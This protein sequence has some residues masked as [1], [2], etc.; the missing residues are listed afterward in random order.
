MERC[1]GR[2]GETG[3]GRRGGVA[4]RRGKGGGTGGGWRGGEFGCGG[5]SLREA[6]NVILHRPRK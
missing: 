4:G 1:E 6:L 5:A 2:R 3:G